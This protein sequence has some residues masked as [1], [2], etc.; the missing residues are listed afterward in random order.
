VEEALA[1]KLPCDKRTDILQADARSL[2]GVHVAY[3]HTLGLS[4]AGGAS[5]SAAAAAPSKY[6]SAF[7]FLGLASAAK[8]IHVPTRTSASNRCTK[9]DAPDQELRSAKIHAQSSDANSSSQQGLRPQHHQSP[10]ER[11]D[12]M[13]QALPEC[14]LS[15]PRCL[16]HPQSPTSSFSSSSAQALPRR[17]PLALQSSSCSADSTTTIMFGPISRGRGGKAK[18]Q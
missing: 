13:Q 6:R 10:P 7:F 18:I 8:Q 15:L 14:P 2:D 4:A 3:V 9:P 1:I 12:L 5:A 16:Q 17:W 11:A